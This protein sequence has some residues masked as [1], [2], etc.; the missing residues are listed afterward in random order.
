MAEEEKEM[1]FRFRWC[2][3]D[4]E[5]GEICQVLLLGK[6]DAVPPL[7]IDIAN[8]LKDKNISIYPI[9]GVTEADSS[10]YHF[11]L[12]FNPGILVEPQSISLES[13]NWSISSEGDANAVSLYLLWTGDETILRPNEAMEIILTGVA[14]QTLTDGTTRSLARTRAAGT[15]T[16]DVT[17][18]WQLE[19]GI[20]E[21]GDPSDIT[22]RLPGQEDEY[23]KSTTLTLNMVQATGKSNIPLFVGFVNCNKVLNTNNELSNL[24][25]RITNTNLPGTLSTTNFSSSSRLASPPFEGP[26]P[27]PAS[28][29]PPDYYPPDYHPE[30]PPS[31]P[32]P[33]DIT[34][35]PKLNIVF[36]YDL[37]ITLSSQLVVMLEVGTVQAAPW[38]LATE[39]QL[40]DIS[41]EIEG[42][43]W[44]Q[45]GVQTIEV[46]GITKAIQWSFIPQNADVILTAQETMLINLSNIVT[47]HPTGETNL[48]LY[49]KRVK[50]YKD[51]KFTCQ[52]EKGPLTL[53]DQEVRIGNT[54]EIKNAGPLVFRSDVDK[55]RDQSS[56][57]FF[58]KDESSPLMNLDSDAD[59]K[60]VDTLTAYRIKGDGAV[61][62]GMILMWSGMEDDI[63]FGWKLCDGQN[64]RPDLRG[65]FIVG[66]GQ[67][68][69]RTNYQFQEQGG[70]DSVTLTIEQMPSHSHGVT[71]DG[72]S[73][74][75]S[76][77]KM[78]FTQA[79][80]GSGI[81]D[82]QFETKY[83]V[84]NT[85]GISIDEAGDDQ[86]FDNRPCYYALC[87]I[88]K[89]DV[90]EY[91][92]LSS[93]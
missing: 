91:K 35:D 32:E 14:A 11:K 10:N 47:N 65:R 7:H 88:M 22:R 20:I 75:F 80:H 56:V 13:E 93:L 36:Q 72:H 30:P 81:S 83:T 43:Q 40:N 59:L 8:D 12:A 34:S 41:V 2:Y 82:D 44:R 69:E 4:E 5:E 46:G 45:N 70:A 1:P 92:T 37:D 89:V 31:T 76:S 86:S 90:S 6:T 61:F 85:T 54:A 33:P 60:V 51:G 50:D 73:H 19:E 17:I 52:I 38:A 68:E 84:S 62:T 29:H 26:G 49:Y 15:A 66:V 27:N 25:L 74:Q 67:N 78:R 3:E 71:D 53:F 39:D 64:G 16:T 87:F 28:P 58:V 24:Q 42:G 79:G 57:Q 23:A 77:P 48:Y 21:I 55:T 9:D 18:S 63:P